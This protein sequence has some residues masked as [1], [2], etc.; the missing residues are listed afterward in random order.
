MKSFQR[1]E[2]MAATVAINEF[3][4]LARRGPSPVN[5]E[6]CIIVTT[7]G[8]VNT[9]QGRNLHEASHKICLKGIYRK[10]HL[11]NSS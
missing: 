2:Y 3:I 1:V 10:R 8:T 11:K 5:N 4:E 9:Y 6:F 7:V